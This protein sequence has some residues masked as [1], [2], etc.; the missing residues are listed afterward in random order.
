MT[1]V[2]ELYGITNSNSIGMEYGYFLT[3]LCIG[4]VTTEAADT[5]RMDHEI[6]SDSYQHYSFRM[7]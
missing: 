7:Y 3:D 4:F 6:E 1:F 2:H 5:W